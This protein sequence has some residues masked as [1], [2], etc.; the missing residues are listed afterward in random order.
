[1]KSDK[2]STRY[3]VTRREVNLSL[4]SAAFA[5]VAG[6][7]QSARAASVHLF[8]F[9]IAGG[10]YYELP[11]E[12]PKLQPGTRLSLVREADNRHDANAVAVHTEAG[13]KLGFIPRCANT[14]VAQLLDAGREV[15]AEVQRLLQIRRSRDVPEDLV[16]T[17]VTSGDP[18]VRLTTFDPQEK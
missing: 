15:H 1:M 13:A 7:P 3:E 18:I 2:E 11:G 10:F 8:D 6:L 9:A 17:H 14:P 12:L 5:A 16:F 4:L